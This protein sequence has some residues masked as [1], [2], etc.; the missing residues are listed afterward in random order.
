MNSTAEFAFRGSRNVWTHSP[1]ARTAR[2]E[3]LDTKLEKAVP[4][5]Q[6]AKIGPA[7]ADA[8]SVPF[9]SALSWTGSSA[10]ERSAA[11]EGRRKRQETMLMTI[12]LIT[13]LR[14]N[15]YNEMCMRSS[16]LATLLAQ[17]SFVLC[18]Y[19]MAISSRALQM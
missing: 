10:V 5:M 16:Y 1:T 15:V 17:M 13:S 4:Q 3:A 11:T 9:I 2:I 6:R 14:Y 7:V 8:A 18:T 19:R 12:R